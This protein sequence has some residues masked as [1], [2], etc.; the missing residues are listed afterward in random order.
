MTDETLKQ[1]D[2]VTNKGKTKILLEY[3][4]QQMII[5]EVETVFVILKK[6]NY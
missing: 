4:L 2:S 3:T 1:R 5:M 6:L